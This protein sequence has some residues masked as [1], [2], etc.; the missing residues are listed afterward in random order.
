MKILKKL[1]LVAVAAFSLFACNNEAPKPIVI[2]PDTYSGKLTV[3]YN[4]ADQVSDV[5]IQVFNTKK[6][7]STVLL[8]KQ[9]KF[10]D[11][12]PVKLDIKIPVTSIIQNDSTKLS[13]TGITP[14]LAGAVDSPFPSFR[15]DNVNGFI[16][17]DSL[18]VAM[19]MIAVNAIGQTVAEGT[20]FPTRFEGAK[21]K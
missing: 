11:A 13:G 7:D 8:F 3:T 14:Y 10:V 21:K 15:I 5:D 16:S 12:M 18:N 19:D 4:G 6:S 1:I 9:V 20:I 2:N 17:N